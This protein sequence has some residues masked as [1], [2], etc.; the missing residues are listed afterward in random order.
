M[1][2][3]F[4]HFDPKD[5][6]VI[7]DINNSDIL[8]NILWQA[9]SSFAHNMGCNSWGKNEEDRKEGRTSEADA[10]K[11]VKVEEKRFPTTE[12][13]YSSYYPGL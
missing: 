6:N 1:F 5:V 10:N 7:L 11:N 3:P 2:F 9:L 12:E 4:K 8:Q 13:H